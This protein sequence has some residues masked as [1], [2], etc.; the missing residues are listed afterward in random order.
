M[1]NKKKVLSPLRQK[2]SLGLDQNFDAEK[3]DKMRKKFL[4][5]K[6]G[7]TFGALSRS[8]RELLAT[9]VAILDQ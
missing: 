4:P 3:M 7:R 5:Q 1:K 9:R 6:R 2:E 8:T